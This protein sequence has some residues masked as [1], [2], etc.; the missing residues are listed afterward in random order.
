MAG[1]Q[2]AW[3]EWHKYLIWGYENYNE[4]QIL[5]DAING[6]SSQI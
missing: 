2:E 6:I 4:E 3:E 1:A 5:N